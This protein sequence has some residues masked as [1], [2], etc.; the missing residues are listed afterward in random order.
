MLLV[1][2]LLL[3][4]CAAH[5]IHPSTA[6]KFDSDAYD[7]LSITDSVIQS[8]KSALAANQFPVS[9]AGNV[10]SALNR[11]IQ[12]Y[13]IAET[14]YCGTPITVSTGGVSS[15][16][17]ATNSYHAMAM[18]GTATPVQ[19]SQL[20]TDLTNVNAASSAISTA[21]GTN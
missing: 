9:I 21:K 5:P 10:K 2:T 4:G 3:T 13:D 8:T 6:N 17:C 15:L 7:T 14:F 1:V 11:L 16:V 18:A 12:V 19:S 20:S